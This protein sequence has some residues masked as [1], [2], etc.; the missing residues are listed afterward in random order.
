[1]G[2][3]Y[4]SYDDKPIEHEDMC[5]LWH[6]SFGSTT[7]GIIAV[8]CGI[9]NVWKWPE[10][11]WIVCWHKIFSTT[12]SPLGANNWEPVLIYNKGKRGERLSD[13]FQATFINDKI[14]AQHPCPKPLK[15]LKELIKILS[16]PKELILDPFLGSG[17]TAVAAKQLGRKCIGI[18]IEEKYLKIAK[19][20]LGIYVPD[21][22]EKNGLG[23][24]F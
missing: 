2:L 8:F 4:E 23:L 13:Y 21:L 6:K 24:K 17:T 3:K 22:E 18:E 10:A 11:Y 14:A 12:R 15:A 9:A 5:K 1:V 20:R 7:S 16:L 19:S